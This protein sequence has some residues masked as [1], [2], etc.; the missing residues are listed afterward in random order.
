MGLRVRSAATGSDGDDG[1]EESDEDFEERIYAALMEVAR[2]TS[3]RLRSQLGACVLMRTKYEKAPESV[4]EA[5]R[6]FITR[7]EL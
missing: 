3:G 2:A 7:A 6:D 4:R 5:I 1:D